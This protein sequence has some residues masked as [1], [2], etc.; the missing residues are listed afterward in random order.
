MAN[1]VTI[2]PETN[3]VELTDQRRQIT[4]TDNRT[5]TSINLTQTDPQVL[6]V[7]SVGPQGSKGDTGAQGPQGPIGPMGP[8][9]SLS[10]FT[11]S[12]QIT[13]SLSV[14]GSIIADSITGSLSGSIITTDF[15]YSGDVLNV[16]GNVFVQGTLD[17][18]TKNFKIDHPTK[19]DYYLVHSS[20]EGPERGIYYRGKLQNNTIIHLPEYWNELT[21]ED[22]ITVQLT[23]IKSSCVHYVKSISKQKIEVG[24]NCG[25]P[26]CFYIVH[27]ERNNE[28]KFEILQPK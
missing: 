3:K 24:C 16:L 6:R 13:G 19:P 11:G 15:T 17:A 10:P 20:L 26:Y 7:S 22:N 18:A 21:D 14:T 25:E 28:G 5:G 8:S 9:G 1:Q 23:S 12:A 4:V 27:A 2:K